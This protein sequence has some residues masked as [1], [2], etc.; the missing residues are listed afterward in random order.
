MDKNCKTC[1]HRAVCMPLYHRGAFEGEMCEDYI[2]VSQVCIFSFGIGDTAYWLK[3]DEDSVTVCKG[4]I[5]AMK[6]NKDREIRYRVEGCGRDLQCGVDVFHSRPH[7]K[8][9]LIC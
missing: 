5:N 8:G 1:V 7:V 6:V 3:N 9:D 4:T 2:G